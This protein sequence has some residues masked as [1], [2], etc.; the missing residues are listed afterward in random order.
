MICIIKDKETLKSIYEHND[1]SDD[2]LFRIRKY[3]TDNTFPDGVD[4]F[5]YNKIISDDQ[6]IYYYHLKGI[7]T[8]KDGKFQL[9]SI[10]KGINKLLSFIVERK[11]IEDHV[12][13]IA[14]HNTRNIHN[15]VLE[16]LKNT[17][18]HSELVHSS[19]KVDFVRDII[20]SD[21]NLSNIPKDILATL[22]ALEQV[23][24]D[25]DIIDFITMGNRF[26]DK[27]YTET[28]VHTL[29]VL[30][31]YLYEYDFNKKNIR[32]NIEPNHDS[33][34][35]NFYTFRSAMSLIFENCL[36][37]TK[38]NS[39]IVLSHYR[40]DDS[41]IIKIKMTSIRNDD[42]EIEKI[43]LPEYRGKNAQK[44]LPSKGKG[45]GL[46]VAKVLLDLNGINLDFV[47]CNNEVIEE[48][49]VIYCDNE[50]RI[51]IPADRINKSV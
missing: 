20:N 25:Y 30:V 3:V 37:Y 10:H 17:F 5:G 51:I 40:I 19:N 2:E 45:L 38:S 15:S 16:R 11:E 43:F 36:K 35:V 39:E 44:L 9:R 29:L 26:D 41:Y 47:K 31:F 8:S 48:H 14:L 13:E 32:I 46:Y 23:S 22:K 27:D 1:L 28:K 21:S 4:K 24:F 50:Y 6:N 42:E 18:A 33:I 49:G 7:K 34:N 12:K